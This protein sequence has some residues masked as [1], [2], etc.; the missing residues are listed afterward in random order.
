MV[1]KFSKS[2]LIELA[3]DD[4][5]LASS[6]VHRIYLDELEYSINAPISL[7]LLK[8]IVTLAQPV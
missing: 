6:R 4:F 3:L 7:K 5:L 8:L 1:E 2:Y